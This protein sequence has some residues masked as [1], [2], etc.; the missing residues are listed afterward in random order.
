MSDPI[1]I[2]YRAF[3]SYS[4]ADTRWAKWL[5]KRLENFVIDK[6]LH[7]RETTTGKVPKTLHPVFRDRNDFQTGHS[8]TDQT[9]AA[10]DASGA[11]IVLCSPASAKSEY[12][13]EEIR[14]FKTRHPQRPIV[15]LI[16]QGKPDDP[17]HG[18]FAPALQ[19]QL[20]ADGS[21][22]DQS[23][24][25]IASDI[26][27]TGDGREL[28]L[29]KVVAGVLGLPPDDIFRRAERARRQRLRRWIAGLSGI[30]VILLGLFVYAELN[31]HLANK[32]YQLAAAAAT[33]LVIVQSTI[34]LVSKNDPLISE[35]DLT[36]GFL[37]NLDYD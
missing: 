10:L 13:N 27:E 35:R 18:C 2:E 25:V 16:L 8:L 28:A 30:L 17:D 1:A 9:L 20:A 4:H 31:R 7:G 22:S 26:R 23:S 29:A 14:L 6:E 21:I 5:H 19:F 3:I 11:L 34:S 32:R 37:K 12:V 33:D 24:G 36:R 15:P